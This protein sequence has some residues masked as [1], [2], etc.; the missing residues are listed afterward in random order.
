MP[1]PDLY[2][3]GAPVGW[4][5]ALEERQLHFNPGVVGDLEAQKRDVFAGATPSV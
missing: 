4:Q 5:K 1:S 2:W 3:I